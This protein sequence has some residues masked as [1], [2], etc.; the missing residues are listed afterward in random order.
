MKSDDALQKLSDIC[1]LKHCIYATEKSY[2]GW[3]RSYRRVLMK[4]EGEW[5]S[6]ERAGGVTR[7][8]NEGAP[9]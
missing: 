8:G 4:S 1:R 2:C 3:V 6:G 5:A 7:L 9:M